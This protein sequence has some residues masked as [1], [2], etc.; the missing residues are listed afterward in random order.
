QQTRA[1]AVKQYYRLFTTRFPDVHTLARAKEN[2]VLSLW[3]GLGYYRRARMLH[4]AA[5]EIVAQFDGA[6]PSTASEL[7]RLPGVGPYTAAAIASIA[8][9]EP[10][11]VVDGNV[12][13]VL[14]RWYGTALSSKEYWKHARDLLDIGRPGDWNQA[15]ME[16]GATVCTPRTPRCAACPVLSSCRTR[17]ERK[18]SPKLPARRKKA[19]SYVLSRRDDKVLLLRRAKDRAL[20]AGMWELPLVS[21]QPD[22]LLLSTKHSITTTDFAVSI[23][24]SG[25]IGR[26]GFRRWV[27]VRDLPELALTG[28]TRKI[29]RKLHI[30]DSR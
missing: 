26:S 9:N 19:V 27:H 7:R 29:F 17:G 24:A 14:S 4:S 6:L 30:L 15:M 11:A 22:G 28:L 10:V 5:R 18:P 12:E 3:S 20:M 25:D 2:Q 8:F 21:A 23:Y 1:E 13:R 16:L